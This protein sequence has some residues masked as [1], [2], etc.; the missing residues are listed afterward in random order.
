MV[1]RCRNPLQ[2]SAQSRA[3][4]DVNVENDTAEFRRENAQLR[5]SIRMRRSFNK[6]RFGAA[7]KL[8]ARAASEVTTQTEKLFQNR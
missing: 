4:Y 1:R 6:W 3:T 2:S 7:K 8:Q 5:D